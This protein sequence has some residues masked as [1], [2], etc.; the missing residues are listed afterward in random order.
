MWRKGGL[1]EFLMPTVPPCGV[2]NQHLKQ[3]ELQE[4]MRRTG[5]DNMGLPQPFQEQAAGAAGPTQ[6]A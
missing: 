5:E 6:P 1:R 2:H 3:L 4:Q